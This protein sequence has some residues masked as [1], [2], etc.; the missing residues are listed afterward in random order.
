MLSSKFS[1]DWELAGGVV[2]PCDAKV[3]WAEWPTG[4]DAA[5]ADWVFSGVAPLWAG[6]RLGT[7]LAKDFVTTERGLRRESPRSWS[8]IKQ[9]KQ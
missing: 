6:L 8:I 7:R 9:R 4:V 3:T 2:P 1:S 5:D